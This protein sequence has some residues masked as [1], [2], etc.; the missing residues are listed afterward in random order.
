ML[1]WTLWDSDEICIIV[2]AF[3]RGGIY[4]RHAFFI[5]VRII[6]RKTYEAVSRFL[7]ERRIKFLVPS[8][9]LAASCESRTVNRRIGDC[10]EKYS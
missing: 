3:K 2:K 4:D 10:K 9:P 7:V 1:T 6:T 5:I 8:V